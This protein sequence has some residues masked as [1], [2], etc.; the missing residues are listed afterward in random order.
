MPEPMMTGTVL[1]NSTEVTLGRYDQQVMLYAK[2][3]YARSDDLA[4]DFRSIIAHISGVDRK[5]VELCHVYYVIAN[6]F[7]FFSDMESQSRR[8]NF[9]KNLAHESLALAREDEPTSEWLA[10]QFLS[11][12]TG[13]KMRDRRDGKFIDMGEPNYDI[14]PK[15]ERK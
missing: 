10:K 8:N 12:I 2:G 14:L 15:P 6:A 7:V 4:E 11:F 13:V 5:N 1:P 3:Y 9:I